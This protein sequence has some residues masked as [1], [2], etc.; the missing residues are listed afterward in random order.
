MKFWV[1]PLPVPFFV[2]FIC[3]A[4]HRLISTIVPQD[5]RGQI[6]QASNDREELRIYTMIWVVRG[7]NYSETGICIIYS[8][9]EFQMIKLMK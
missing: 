6:A 5:P 9:Y 7:Q 1:T 8:V 3:R 4:R 2:F